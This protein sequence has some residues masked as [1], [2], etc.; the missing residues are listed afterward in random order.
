MTVPESRSPAVPHAASSQH[1]IIWRI[2]VPPLGERI[3]WRIAFVSTARPT[4]G[5]SSSSAATLAAD[6]MAGRW[7]LSGTTPDGTTGVDLRVTA[8][9]PG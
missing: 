3:E 6:H 4:V 7:V 2:A 1:M 5:G 9:L 8:Q